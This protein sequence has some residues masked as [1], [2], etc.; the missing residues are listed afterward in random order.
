MG[1]V[2]ESVTHQPIPQVNVFITSDHGTVQLSTDEQGVFNYKPDHTG[3]F[4]IIL[5]HLDVRQILVEFHHRF[6]DNEA[7]KTIR[8]I[9]L[10]NDSGY[11]IFS[12][13]ESGEEYSFIRMAS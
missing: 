11:K 7:K 8:T 13:S 6:L 12:V 4:D 3:R 5:S 2:Y 9:K 1:F 10:L